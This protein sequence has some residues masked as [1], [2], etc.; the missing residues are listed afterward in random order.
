VVTITG[1]NLRAVNVVR[2]GSKEVSVS[3][4]SD[5][6]IT[7]S[8]PASG[9][10]SAVDVTVSNGFTSA[11]AS[12]TKFVYQAVPAPLVSSVSPNIISANTYAVISLTGSRLTDVISVQIESVGSVNFSVKS[13]EELILYSEYLSINGKY[14]ITIKT[15]WQ[16]LNISD[17]LTVIGGAP[18][19]PTGLIGLSIN[20]GAQF[21]NNL[22]VELSLVWPMGATSVTVSNDGGFTQGTSLNLLVK[23]KISWKLNPKAVVPIPAI[24]YV[25]F[26]ND[27]QTY[28]E[29]ILVDSIS[30]ILTFVSASS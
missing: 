16:T 19:P 22:V 13:D 11:T 21:T 14:D 27:P 25:R 28:F 5:V 1:T 4:M 26:E 7:V 20:S 15:P 18:M 29:D 2:F 6:E 30:P 8:V 10:A 17:A 3:P 23:D 9:T 12:P 24:V